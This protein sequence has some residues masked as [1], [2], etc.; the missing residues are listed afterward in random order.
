MLR[1]KWLMMDEYGLGG[2]NEAI[3]VLMIVTMAVILFSTSLSF[4]AEHLIKSKENDR[5]DKT[6]ESLFDVLQ[7][8]IMLWDDGLLVLTSF[9]LRCEDPYPVPE[10][11]L[12]YKITLIMVL[13]KGS[14]TFSFNNGLEMEGIDAHHDKF[15]VSVVAQTGDVVPGMIE[16]V[17]W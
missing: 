1:R 10:G 8:D 9:H 6:T 14:P 2:F 16:M 5:Y 17:V 13:E 12:G 11:A 7:D 15:P 3:M 4:S